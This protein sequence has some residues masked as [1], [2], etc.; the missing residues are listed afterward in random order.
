MSHYWYVLTTDYQIDRHTRETENVH[1]NKFQ[2]FRNNKMMSSISTR[3]QLKPIM[4]QL[5]RLYFAFVL[6]ILSQ[7]HV[8]N[9][10]IS[11]VAAFSTATSF[12]SNHYA[13][14]SFQSITSTDR[15]VMTFNHQLIPSTLHRN[16]CRHRPSIELSS[17]HKKTRCNLFRNFEDTNSISKRIRVETISAIDM[18]VSK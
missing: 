3:R 1:H 7:Q 12:C 5:H 8:H 6:W 16:V 11:E 14:S 17:V 10:S 15:N 9:G 4:I 2:L 18:L 13:S